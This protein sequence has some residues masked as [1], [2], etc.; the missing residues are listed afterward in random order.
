VFALEV[1]HDLN[2][3]PAVLIGCL[4]AEAVTLVLMRRSI[5]T[6]KVA[7]RGLH[8]AYDLGVDPLDLVRVG[9]IMDNKVISIP[10][11]MTVAELTAIIAKGDT[12][13]ARRQGTPIVDAAGKLVGIITRGD[14]LKA[15]Q[16]PEGL[17]QPVLQAGSHDLAVAY[18][19]ESLRVAV[20]RMLQRGVGRLPVVSREDQ[21]QLLGYLGRTGVMEARHKQLQDENVR[22]QSWALRGGTHA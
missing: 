17:T 16:T 1:T 3:L 10:A 18:P 21:Q 12:P 20:D 5:V 19:D 9:E 2:A 4:A 15:M 8:V 7:R 22:E 14:V 11:T 6:A 13:L